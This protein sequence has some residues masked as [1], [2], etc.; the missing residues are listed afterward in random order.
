MQGG[1]ASPPGCERPPPPLAGMRRLRVAVLPSLGA[2]RVADVQPWSEPGA[3]EGVRVAWYAMASERSPINLVAWGSLL[4]SAWNGTKRRVATRAAT[5]AATTF[6]F[7]AA[8]DGTRQRRIAVLFGRCAGTMKGNRVVVA[9]SGGVDSSLAA[10]L[11]VEEGYDVVGVSMR[12]WESEGSVESGCC[13]LDDF[14]DARRVADQLGISFY[15]MDFRDEFR[16]A[17]VEPFVAEYRSGRTPNPCARCNQFVK[18]SVLWDRARALGADWMATGHYARRRVVDQDVQLLRAVDAEKDQSYFLFGV[19]A[20]LLRRTL[21]PIGELKKSSVRHEAARRGLAVAEKPDSQEVCFAPPGSYAA[22]VEQY[23]STEPIRSGSIVDADGTE[24]GRH[25]GIHQFTIGQRRGLHLGD[26][27][28]PRYVTAIDASAG[29]VRVGGRDTVLQR[30]LTVRAVNW[31]A[32]KPQRGDELLVKIRSRFSPEPVVVSAVG[33]DWF[34]LD[35]V[36]SL[37]AP[38]PGQAAV[39]YAGERVVGGGW[40]SRVGAAGARSAADEGAVVG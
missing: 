5:R 14:L 27:G 28:P 35:A 29:V 38:T 19:D 39:L 20:G 16:R 11:L 18:F 22:F 8:L 40:I 12:L 2:I 21:F 36:G 23:P 17:V 6:R 26:G 33:D 9:M 7:R 31:L 37:R 3:V 13:T 15:V 10:A 24:L 30:E 25:A 34:A 4:H 1:K 32:P